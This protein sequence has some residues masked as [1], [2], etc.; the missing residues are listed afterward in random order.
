MENEILW[1]CPECDKLH[2]LKLTPEQVVQKILT[3]IPI[4]TIKCDC[5][6]THE[7][8]LKGTRLKWKRID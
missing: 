5:E 8:S 1:N 3:R 6:I 7:I 4:A 2:E